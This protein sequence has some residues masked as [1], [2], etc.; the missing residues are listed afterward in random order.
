MEF[1]VS[2]MNY[3][4]KPFDITMGMHTYFDIS[5]LKNIQIEGPF[6]GSATTDKVS[7]A[8]GTA[9]SNV[10]T[11]TSPVDML[12][13]GVTGPLTITDSGKVNPNF[14]LILHLMFFQ[15]TKIIMESKGFPDSVLWNPYGNEAMGYDKFVCVE[16]VQA[17]PISIPADKNNVVKFYQKISCV[18]I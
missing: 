2:V 15:G 12:Y 17:S 14:M 5:S 10:I 18:K 13:S 16:P 3:G 7:G 4:D 8:K 9:D 11:V 6:K 1:S